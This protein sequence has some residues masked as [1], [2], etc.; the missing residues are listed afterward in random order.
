MCEFPNTQHLSGAFLLFFRS[1]LCIVL[2]RVDHEMLVLQ[3][4][5]EEIHAT[6]DTQS[7][8]KR[9]EEHIAISGTFLAPFSSVPSQNGRK[10]PGFASPEL[11]ILKKNISGYGLLGLI[12]ARQG[13]RSS[14]RREVGKLRTP[15]RAT[16]ALRG[17]RARRLRIYLCI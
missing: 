13:F 9:E 14:S 2:V 8:A 17:A 11:L 1:S 12:S 5:N 4:E 16:S 10:Y 15:T 6:I 7:D 3:R